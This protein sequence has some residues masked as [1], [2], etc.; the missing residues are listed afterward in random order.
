MSKTVVLLVAAILAFA[1]AAFLSKAYTVIWW[2]S[3]DF[4]P[5]LCVGLVL[6]TAAHL[7]WRE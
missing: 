3:D 6:F 5:M 2:D 4:G 7:P 1:I